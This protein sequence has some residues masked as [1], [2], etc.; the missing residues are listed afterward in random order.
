MLVEIEQR[1]AELKCHHEELEQK[2]EERTGEILRAKD[3]AEAANHAKSQFLANMSHEIRTPINGVLGSTELLLESE[4][5]PRQRSLAEMVRYSGESLL[6]LINDILDFSKI[7]AG[8]MEL[9]R[10]TFCLRAT[11]EEAVG[12]LAEKAHRKGL[13]LASLIAAEVPDGF[14]GDPGRLRQILVNLIGNAVKFTERG[15]VVV[16]VSCAGKAERCTVLHFEVADS[17]SGI[18]P[19]AQSRIFEQF[20]QGDGSMTRKLGGTGLGLAIVKQLVELKGG[21]LGLTSE[22]GVGTSFWFRIPLAEH[23]V[24]SAGQGQRHSL[25]GLRVLLVDDNATILSILQQE[26]SSLGMRCDTARSGGE[27]L[28][29]FRAARKSPYD[30]AILDLMMPDMDG[31]ELA[32]A[33]KEDPQGAGLR[34][35]MLTSFGNAGDQERAH[36]AGIDCYLNKPVRQEQ[37]ITCIGSL[38]GVAGHAAESSVPQGMVSDLGEWNIQVLLVEDNQINRDVC[39]A[40]LENLRCRVTTAENGRKALEELARGRYDLILMDC[41]MPEMDGYQATGC[42]REM[43]RAAAKGSPEVHTPIL[44]LTAHALEGDRERCLRAGMDDY[45]TKPLSKRNL[46]A[47]LLRWLV[48]SER[49]SPGQKA[50][51][52]VALAK[53]GARLPKSG[54][55]RAAEPDCRGAAVIENAALDTIRALQKADSPSLLGTVINRYADDSPRLLEAMHQALSD[56]NPAGLR[57][58]AHSLKSSSAYLGARNLVELCQEM[59]SLGRDQVSAGAAQLL[60]RIESEY[61][62]AH[63]VLAGIRVAEC[64]EDETGRAI[65]PDSG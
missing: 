1:D 24:A 22:E 3:A 31:V 39:C 9:E 2:V 65:G 37:L 23:A 20:S 17:G 46:R 50:A 56:D 18:A 45:L 28:A 35:L 36:S 13:E 7:E 62:A 8:K 14:A 49:V 64:P 54:A 21:E 29:L 53:G 41:Q 15:E 52:R 58:A 30:L 38:M 48:K 44:A 61:A 51:Q 5:T 12:M 33:I 11:V 19:E 40:M 16:T 6:S 27:A 26:I 47:A 59:E 60:A 57:L 10:V 25:H 55:E 4:L 32:R 42:I 63:Q 34:L 43:E